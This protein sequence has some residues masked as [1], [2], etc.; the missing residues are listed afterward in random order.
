MPVE[1]FPFITVSGGAFER[2]R[3]YGV[4][5]ASRIRRSADLYGGSL[6]QLGLPA[7][8]KAALIQSYADCIAEFDESYIEEM[9][10]IAEGSGV[11]FED[12]VM[13]NARTE[14]V[15]SARAELNKP[16]PDEPDDGCTCAL[17]MPERSS[18]GHLI[19]G[20]NWD[21]R[22]ECAETGVVLRVR[23]ENGP[24]FVTFV[25]AGGL[26]R[27]GFNAAGT[28]ITANYLECERDFTQRGVPLGAIRRK[29]LQNE[30]FARA[31]KVVATTPKS[32]SNN[33]MI[34]TSAGFGIDFECAPD[35]SFPLYPEDGLLVHANHWVSPVALSKLR[36]TGIPYVPESFYRDWRVRRLLEERG[37]LLGR[38]DLKAALFDDF[39]TPFSVCR[40]PRENEA[41]NISTTV[42]MVVIDSSRGFME[43]A[44]LPALNREFRTYALD[45]DALLPADAGARAIPASAEN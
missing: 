27:S 34:S 43:I 40:P 31:I 15:A 4:L 3:Q 33:I 35:E 9:R 36:D 20:Q 18:T 44:A 39:L 8:R 16:E 30:H 45:D 14:I 24:D 12:I 2:G 38:A 29:V 10:G 22:V 41:S 21:W 37:P 5:L 26:A 11:A 25:E 32:C 13:I 7:E 6:H 23:Q 19:H 17:I 1:P 42:A 28:A